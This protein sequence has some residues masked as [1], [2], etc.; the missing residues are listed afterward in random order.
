MNKNE[1]AVLLALRPNELDCDYHP[2]SIKFCL[3][4]KTELKEY[5]PNCRDCKLRHGLIEL[6]LTQKNTKEEIE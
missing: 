1:V 3:D 2:A 6:F 5:L 4:W